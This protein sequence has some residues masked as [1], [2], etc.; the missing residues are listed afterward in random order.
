M[1]SACT[2]RPSG[3]GWVCNVGFNLKKENNNQQWPLTKA[4][5]DKYFTNWEDLDNE[6]YMDK[7]ILTNIAKD[8]KHI[9]DLEL[10][11]KKNSKKNKQKQKEYNKFIKSELNGFFE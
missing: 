8:M 1:K 4:M 10:E 3:Y 11:K 7:E 5:L 9:A 2:I 6:L